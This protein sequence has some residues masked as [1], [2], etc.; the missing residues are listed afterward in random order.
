MSNDIRDD[1]QRAAEEVMRLVLEDKPMNA[2]IV[3]ETIAKAMGFSSA[4]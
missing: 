2:E 4:K 1:I 3:A